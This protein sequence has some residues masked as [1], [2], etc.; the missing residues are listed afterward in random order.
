MPS[1]HRELVVWQKAM[2]V[3]VQVYRLTEHFPRSELY[4]LTSQVTRAAASVPANIAEGNG[5]ASRR[6]YA[7][8]LS[9]ARGSLNEMETFLFLAI[10][11]GYLREHETA[12]TLDLITEVGK[13]LI[14]LRGRLV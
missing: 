9:I 10:R 1:S 6:D 11:L 12:S 4:R 5:R 13:M 2:D 8:F 7:N 14:V 3:A